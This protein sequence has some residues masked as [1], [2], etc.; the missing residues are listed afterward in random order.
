[1]LDYLFYVRI[2]FILYRIGTEKTLNILLTGITGL[3]GASFV[4]AL[5]RA[6]KDYKIVAVCRSGAIESAQER[7]EQTIREQCMFDG[8]P[9]TADDILKQITVVD[10]DVK[11]LPF[12]ELEKYAP[13]DVM[14]HCAADVNL[15]KDPDGKTYATNLNGTKNALEAVRRF[16]I[17]VLHY[18][19][20]AYVAGKTDGRVMENDMPAKD[21]NNSYERSKFDAEKLVRSSG[22]PYTIYRPSIIVGRLSDG[23]IRKPL[24]F[25][26]ILEFMGRVKHHRCIKAK[27]KP[28]MP[29]EMPLRLESKI[30]DKIYF[31]PIDFVQTAISKLFMLPVENKTYHLTGESPVST[32][33]INTAVASILQASGLTVQE[34]VENPSQD[35]KLVVRMISDLLP[36]F[37]SQIVFDNS[38]IKNAL[39]D[40][41]LAW[42]MDVDFLKRMAHSYY[43]QEI[44]ALLD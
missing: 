9:E 8:L 12:D 5:L 41:A 34:K 33:D 21:F 27:I 26:R 42:R 36:Y 19:S 17:P 37:A 30:S 6:H 20:T 44:P 2:N 18:V 1:M 28:S 39:G 16:K 22:I 25:Y 24:A 29:L 10:G 7:A 32:V 11:C 31:V 13:Y 3:V 38:E 40:D 14:F 23:L 43:K 35:E 4:T 15:G